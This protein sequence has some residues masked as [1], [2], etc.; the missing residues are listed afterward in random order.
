MVD[1]RKKLI[2][3]FRVSSLSSLSS[4]WQLKMV[5]CLKRSQ[6]YLIRFQSITLW[7]S[8]F[9]IVSLMNLFLIF[10]WIEIVDFRKIFHYWCF[11]SFSSLNMF[12]KCFFFLGKKLFLQ[13]SHFYRFYHF[14]I[15][16]LMNSKEQILQFFLVQS[17]FYWTFIARND[18]NRKEKFSKPF[19]VVIN[20][21][22]QLFLGFINF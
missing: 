17:T 15:I 9:F 5:F 13:Q 18:I 19:N 3:V 1:H 14:W 20:P 7:I 8:S 22:L 4:L 21:L 11:Y 16:G 2:R 12:D 10:L 6:I